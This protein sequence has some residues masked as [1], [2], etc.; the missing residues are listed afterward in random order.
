[1]LRVLQVGRYF[2]PHVGG[3]ETLVFNLAEGL[4]AKGIRCDVLCSNKEPVYELDETNGFKVHRTKSYGQLLS[5]SLTPQLIQKFREI[6]TGYDIV[7]LHHPDPIATMALFYARPKCKVVIHWHSDILRQKVP[8]LFFMPLQNWMLRRADA[9]ITTSPNYAKGSGHL[10]SYMDKVHV[11]P[12]GIRP[13]E[14]TPTRE[15]IEKVRTS[16]GD[17]KVIFSLGRLVYYK[18]FEYLIDAA[19]HLDDSYLILIGG[20]GPLQRRLSGLI[21]RKGLSERVRILGQLTT[22]E[23]ALYYEL[24]NVFCLPSIYRTE[25]FGIVLLEAMSL[26][27]PLVTTNLP[28]SG[29]SWVNQHNVTGLTVPPR[30]GKALADAIRTATN[31]QELASRFSTAAKDRFYQHFT[32]DA[33]IDSMIRLY[34]GVMKTGN[35]EY[36]TAIHGM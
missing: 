10:G 26:G 31:D 20:D 9:I 18:G 13:L 27:K 7:H 25:A 33:M 34:S 24:A 32:V 4:N 19:S 17:K 28:D 14:A 15:Q 6:A 1:M 36:A 35:S 30:D 21:E 8:L 5:L 23:V 3:V 11:I 22:E 29:V 16:V 12:I 2:P